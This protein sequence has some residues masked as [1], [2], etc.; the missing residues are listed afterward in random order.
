MFPFHK[1][2]YLVDAWVRTLAPS[3]AVCLNVWSEGG[4]RSTLSDGSSWQQAPPLVT[5]T[6][7]HR[8]N[9]SLVSCINFPQQ[10]AEAITQIFHIHYGHDL[11]VKFKSILNQICNE[12]IY[13][14]NN[15]NSKE[16]IHA[17]GISY[18]IFK[19]PG[20]VW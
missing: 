5:I 1:D 10:Q 12:L 13:L 7:F 19:Y 16:R 6:N 9:S 4:G 2:T 20:S 11:M 17:I 3:Y 15:I 18:I 14:T 8:W